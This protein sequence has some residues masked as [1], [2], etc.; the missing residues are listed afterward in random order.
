M[1]Y[2]GLSKKLTIFPNLT[3]NDPHLYKDAKEGKENR[4]FA[5]HHLKIGVQE[6]LH[7]QGGRQLKF[8][9]GSVLVAHRGFLYQQG[10]RI[11]EDRQH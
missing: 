10:H 5:L 3:R 4:T 2:S 6:S 1:A 11:E 8:L 9:V 7:A